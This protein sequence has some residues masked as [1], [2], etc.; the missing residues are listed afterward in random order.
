MGKKRVKIKDKRLRLPSTLRKR[1]GD[2]FGKVQLNVWR[3]VT[4]VIFAVTIFIIGRTLFSI[5]KMKIEISHLNREKQAY[6]QSIKSDSL[7][8]ESLKYDECLEE[9]ARENFHMQRKGEQVFIFEED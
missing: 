9:Y 4:L 7:L 5:A 2:F 3:I 6:L 8:L 1:I